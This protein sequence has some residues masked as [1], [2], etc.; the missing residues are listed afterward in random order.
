LFLFVDTEDKSAAAEAVFRN[1]AP[2][3][4]AHKVI[5]SISKS[6]DG[7]GHYTRLAEYVGVDVKTVEIFELISGPISHARRRW[8]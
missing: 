6:N 5:F 1:T 8:R 4:K 2:K 3:A 7:F